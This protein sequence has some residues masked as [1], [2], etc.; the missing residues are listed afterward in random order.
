MPVAPFPGNRYGK[1]GPQL[2]PSQHSKEI[3]PDRACTSF[4]NPD[5]GNW[6]PGARVG[7]RLSARRFRPDR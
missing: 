5:R 3:S 7:V 2:P 4:E 1:A 6:P